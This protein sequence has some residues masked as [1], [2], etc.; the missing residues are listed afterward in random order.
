MAPYRVAVMNDDITKFGYDSM[1]QI[2]KKPKFMKSTSPSIFRVESLT[3]NVFVF[4]KN[5]VACE[6]H[7]YGRM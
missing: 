7:F 4:Y 3:R 6:V 1:Q 2:T 5:F